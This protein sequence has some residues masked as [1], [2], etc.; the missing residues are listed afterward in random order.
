MKCIQNTKSMND[1]A[2]PTATSSDQVKCHRPITAPRTR[3]LLIG[4]IVV[5]VFYPLVE[6]VLRCAA[7]ALLKASR[8]ATQPTRYVQQVDPPLHERSSRNSHAILDRLDAR[9]G[10]GSVFHRIAF[11]PIIYLS[12]KDHIVAIADGDPNCV[13]F[14]LGVPLQGLL[15]FPFD[16]LGLDARLDFDA[17]DHATHARE[18][19]NII[20]SVLFLIVPIDAT[21]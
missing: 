17:V 7:K 8:R 12:L 14:D 13:R 4:L 10:P 20:L 6:I 16:V 9:C 15:D 3:P 2:Q 21:S 5:M 11:V 18:L 1:C 19:S